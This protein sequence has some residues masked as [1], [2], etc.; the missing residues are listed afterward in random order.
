MEKNLDEIE[1]YRRYARRRILQV[2]ALERKKMKEE[3]RYPFEFGWYTIEEINKLQQDR[4]RRDR[5][6]FLD[7]LVLFVVMAFFILGLFG[8][9]H[10]LIS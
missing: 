5:A 3:G 2:L 4:K 6:L 10:L 8:V 9:I 1:I 7:L